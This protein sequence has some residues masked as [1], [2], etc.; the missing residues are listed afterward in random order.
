MIGLANTM[1]IGDALHGGDPYLGALNASR[2]A[3]AGKPRLTHFMQL[4]VIRLTV[5]CNRFIQ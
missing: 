3:R 4:T 5:F 1:C 2:S